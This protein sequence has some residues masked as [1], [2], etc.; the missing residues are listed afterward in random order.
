[1]IPNFKELFNLKKADIIELAKKMIA[2]PSCYSGLKEVGQNWIDSVGTDGEKAAAKKLIAELE[3]DVTDIDHLV[4]FAH[5]E[6]PVQ[7]FGAE[8]AKNFAAH[9]DELKASGAEF[10]DCGACAPGLEILKN[11]SLILD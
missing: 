9:A 3:G 6:I 1:M 10:C 2:A 8:G 7:M 5:S 11:K 4:A